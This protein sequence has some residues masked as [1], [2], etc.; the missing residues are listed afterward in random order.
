MDN[1]ERMKA[2]ASAYHGVDWQSALARD[3]AEHSPDGLAPAVRTVRRWASGRSP[4]APWVVAVLPTLALR[5]AG[6]LD[7][8][9]AHLRRL[10]RQLAVP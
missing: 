3:L 10:A 6:T 5:Y 7:R 9:A 2:V 8:N 4:V 1:R